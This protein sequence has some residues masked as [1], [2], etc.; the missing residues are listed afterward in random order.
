MRTFSLLIAILATTAATALAAPKVGSWVEYEVANTGTRNNDNS[1][2]PYTLK[3]MVVGE[4]EGKLIYE[5]VTQ[6]VEGLNVTRFH[7]KPNP[8]A[9]SIADKAEPWDR[10][11]VSQ[12]VVQANGRTPQEVPVAAYARHMPFLLAPLH[13]R[14]K[15]GSTILNATS[16]EGDQ[17]SVT[18]KGKKLKATELIEMQQEESK[19]NLG[20]IQLEHAYTI[21]AAATKAEEI[22]V[23]GLATITL[24]MQYESKNSRSTDGE[25]RTDKGTATSKLKAVDYGSKGAESLIVGKPVKM[26]QTNPL[27]FLPLNQKK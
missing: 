6:T 4:E 15:N 7:A 13:E 24:E 3:L 18:V 17:K 27:S 20:F 22:P 8:K 26:E 23:T 1:G 11:S 9:E 16:R 25:T 12:I 10:E 19:V 21:N 5:I 2:K 14:N